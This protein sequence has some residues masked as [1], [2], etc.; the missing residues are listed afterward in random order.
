MQTQCCPLPSFLQVSP[1]SPLSALL[2]LFF[3]RFLLRM[4]P[5]GG[6][7]SVGQGMS[8]KCV[9]HAVGVGASFSVR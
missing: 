5:T 1:D 4:A 2:R 6:N 7:F 3:Y 8:L 9:C